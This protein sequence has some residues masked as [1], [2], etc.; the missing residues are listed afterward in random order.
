VLT[1]T[2]VRAAHARPCLLLLLLLRLLLLLLRLLLLLLRLLPVLSCNL[3]A[4]VWATLCC[5]CMVST[6]MP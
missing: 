4:G 3:T 6:L 2:T 5:C 1:F